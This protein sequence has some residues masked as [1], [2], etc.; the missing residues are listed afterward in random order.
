MM[1]YVK[2]LIA[3]GGVV[4]SLLWL[5]RCQDKSSCGS[6]VEE[7]SLSLVPFC[8]A[9]AV[10]LLGCGLAMRVFTGSHTG[11]VGNAVKCILAYLLLVLLLVKFTSRR[12]F[13]IL[14]I[15]AVVSLLHICVLKITHSNYVQVMYSDFNGPQECILNPNMSAWHPPRFFYWCNY[16]CVCSILGDVVGRS[17]KV[18]QVLNVLCCVM[19]VPPVFIIAEKIGG[20]FMAWF[21]AL[22]M[23]T[24]PCMLV[25][26]TILTNEFL[27]AFL[28]IYFFFFLQECLGDVSPKRILQ[29]AAL[30]GLCLGLGQLFKPIGIVIACAMFV[31][32]LVNVFCK[33]KSKA[34]LWVLT[35]SMVYIGALVSSNVGQSCLSEF[36]SPRALKEECSTG[37]LARSIIMGLNVG[38]KGMW[39]PESGELLSKPN[40]ELRAL[41]KEKIKRDYPLYPSL[42]W[43]KIIIA[44]GSPDW[45]CWY[46]WSIPP[47]YTPSWLNSLMSIWHRAFWLLFLL[48]MSGGMMSLFLPARKG[49]TLSICVLLVGTIVAFTAGLMLVEC[50]SRYKTTL[51]PFFFLVVPYA[52]IW[53]AKDNPFYRFILR[54]LRKSSKCR[55]VGWIYDKVKAFT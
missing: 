15:M 25:Y 44:Y 40:S 43:E 29:N 28:Y 47:N 10:M 27:A 52:R 12:L 4:L 36:A 20:Y 42:F 19:A 6:R 7:T 2:V 39:Y 5:R 41:L 26:S 50:Q 33:R 18:G 53:F 30:A 23:G 55:R 13:A 9:L 3:G 1:D 21:T 49:E 46:C 38:S 11:T 8:I 16:E 31:L 54:K 17:I 32:L 35:C 14:F 48:G 24:A 45:L 22:F 37:G 51:Y 34:V